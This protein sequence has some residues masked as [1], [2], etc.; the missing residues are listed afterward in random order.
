MANYDEAYFQEIYGERDWRAY[1][2]I[3]ADIVRY[4]EPGPILDIGAGTG[5]LVE[6]ARAWGLECQGI[7]GSLEAT[8]IAKRRRPNLPLY[9]HVL[10]QAFPFADLSF[11]TVILNQ[12]IEHLDPTIA[13]H[14]II[15]WA[16]LLRPNGMLLITS[17]SRFNKVEGSKDPTHIHLYSPRELHNLVSSCTFKH[18]VPTNYPLDLL[19]TGTI[20]RKAMSLLFD[21]TNWDR[22]S[23]TA[24]CRAYK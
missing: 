22:L 10:G 12:V 2:P 1:Q 13:E 21:L 9:R 8:S 6:C 3:I 23:A 7:E 20:S 14:T 18:I 4:S 16:R 5:L 24:N 11:Q 19:G 15:Q 17:P